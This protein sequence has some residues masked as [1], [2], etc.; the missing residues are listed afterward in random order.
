MSNVSTGLAEAVARVGDRW[1]LLIVD[2]LTGGARRF[3]ELQRSVDGVAP[4]ILSSRLK[5]LERERLVV[6]R[7]YSRRPVRVD[8]ELTEQGHELAGALRMLAS[9]GARRAPDAPDTRHVVCGSQLDV[10]WWC[11]S[12]HEP[13]DADESELQWV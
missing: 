4:N 13:V 9:W 6:V 12:C 10:R 5:Q 7:P 1:S 3:G 8:Y 11:P 2:A